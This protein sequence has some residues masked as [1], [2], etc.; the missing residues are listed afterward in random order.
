MFSFS[1]RS[2]WTPLNSFSVLE[3]DANVSDSFEPD[4]FVL[5]VHRVPVVRRAILPSI[6]T[7][8]PSF[9]DEQERRLLRKVCSS[10]LEDLFYDY[11]VA[12]TRARAQ[13]QTDLQRITHVRQAQ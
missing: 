7:T 13:R 5:V 11:H 3:S 10:P 2:L 8:N 1:T 6:S 4:V 9:L 12:L